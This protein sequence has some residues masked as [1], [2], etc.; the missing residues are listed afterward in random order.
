MRLVT[1]IPQA[2]KTAGRASASLF[3]LVLLSIAGCGD[4]PSAFDKTCASLKAGMTSDQVDQLFAKFVKAQAFKS[5]GASWD[6]QPTAK[7]VAGAKCARTTVYDER[8]V[9]LLGWPATCLVYFDAEG[10]VIGYQLMH[11]H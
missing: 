4:G 10:K 7:F 5:E 2:R 1:M 3:C 11:P 6:V 9:G 8:P